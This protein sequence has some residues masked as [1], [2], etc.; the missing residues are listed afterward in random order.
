MVKAISS[1][2]ILGLTFLAYAQAPQFFAPETL[3]A[4]N[5]NIQVDY[6]GAPYAYDW[7]GDGDK[8]LLVG[9]FISG[10][11]RLYDNIGTNNAPVFGSY[12][13]LQ[14][15]GGNISLPYG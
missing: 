10:A 2:T 9:Q 14:A 15:G 11:I 4:N 6:Y 5:I 7:D 3:E 1:I 13:W 12:A 8:D